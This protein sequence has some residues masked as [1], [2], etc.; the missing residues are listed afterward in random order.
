MMAANLARYD[1]ER[2]AFMPRES[3][4]QSDFMIVAGP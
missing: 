4:R 3:P 2:F 1:Y